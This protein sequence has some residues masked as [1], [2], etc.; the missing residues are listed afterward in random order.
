MSDIVQLVTAWN[1]V[2]KTLILLLQGL[3]IMED[4]LLTMSEIY[5]EA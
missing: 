2:F 3:G 1:E 4:I 5:S